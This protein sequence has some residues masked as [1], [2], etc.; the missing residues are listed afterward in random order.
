MHMRMCDTSWL[1]PRRFGE[2]CWEL[3]KECATLR[4]ECSELPNEVLGKADEKL[5]VHSVC[6]LSFQFAALVCSEV[7][8]TLWPPVCPLNIVHLSFLH[9]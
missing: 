5:E 4:K 1:D 7:I 3:K 8:D 2:D 9:Q 6:F